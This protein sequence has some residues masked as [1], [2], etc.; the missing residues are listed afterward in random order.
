MDIQ[1]TSSADELDG[2]ND[3]DTITGRE[4]DD[5]L[6]G[7]ADSD[8]YVFEPGFGNDTIIESDTANVIRF[9]AGIVPED[10]RFVRAVDD[11][12]DL[13][14]QHGADSIRVQSFFDASGNPVGLIEWIEFETGQ[15]IS[16]ATLE[17]TETGELANNPPNAQNDSAV[18]RLGET[19]EIDLLSNDTD[20]NGDP[21]QITAVAGTVFAPNTEIVLPSG[22]MISISDAGLATYVPAANL[23]AGLSYGESVTDTFNYQIGDARGG[24]D[25]ATVSVTVEAPDPVELALELSPDLAPGETGTVQLSVTVNGTGGVSGLGGVSA[26]DTSPSQAY[27]VAVS[28]NGGLVADGLS[29]S[30]NDTTFVLARGLAEGD[31]GIVDIA[32]KGTAGPRSTLAAQAQLADTGAVTDIAARVAALQPSFVETSV[33]DRV[34]TNL[35]AQFGETIGSLANVLSVH[36]DKFEGFG[37]NTSSATAAL[38]FAIEAAGDFGSLEERGKIGFLGQGWSTLADIGLKIDRNIGAVAGPDGYRRSACPLDRIGRALYDL[39][40]GGPLRGLVRRYSCLESAG[41]SDI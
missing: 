9:G 32:I 39:E 20:P 34:E 7:G 26:F 22:S 21:L 24:F 37:L 36:A 33:I 27:L 2:T 11:A 31:T 18:I 38:A 35:T 40:L 17:V 16:L 41:A 29:K 30:F 15:Q 28:A 14:I 25:Y 3:D 13:L 8:T 23:V 12:R 19:A 1:G 5:T 4:G 10:L 6:R